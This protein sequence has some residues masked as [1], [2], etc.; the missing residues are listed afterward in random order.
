MSVPGGKCPVQ[1]ILHMHNIES[2]NVLLPVHDDTSTPHVTSTGDH[3]NVAGIKLDEVG[4]F[5]RLKVELDGV[6]DLDSRIGVTDC[7]SIVGDDM[8]DAAGANGDFAHFEE[9][10][11]GLLRCNAVD[12]ETTL[13]IVKETEVL[14]RFLN[15]DNI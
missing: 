3:D 7:A 4:D 14:A 13:N 9:L 11:G 8:G 5:G 15:A 6:V 2:S 10:V 12:G 1:R